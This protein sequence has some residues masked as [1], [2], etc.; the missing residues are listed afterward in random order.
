MLWPNVEFFQNASSLEN[1]GNLCAIVVGALRGIP[2]VEVSSEKNHFF[3]IG[4]WQIG[5]D[6]SLG[7]RTAA[8]R[9]LHVHAQSHWPV[10]NQAA[11]QCRVFSSY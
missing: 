1:G 5:D 3:G 8:E 11:K 2:G 10:R 7:D 4:T 9:V 6:I